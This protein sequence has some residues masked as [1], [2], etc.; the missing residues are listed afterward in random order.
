MTEPGARFSSPRSSRLRLIVLAAVTVL[1]LACWLAFKKLDPLA[2]LEIHATGEKVAL[3]PPVSPAVPVVA[4]SGPAVSKAAG[5]TSAPPPQP[6][7]E[8][9]EGVKPSFDIVRVSPSGDAVIAGR[10][11][12]G[13]E[14]TIAGNGIEV[15]HAQADGHGQWVLLTPVPLGT[16]GQELQLR[17]R[18][19]DGRSAVGDTPVVVLIPEPAAS[20]EKRAL[21]VLLPP[22][23]AGRLLKSE[24]VAGSPATSNRPNLDAVDYDDGGNIRFAGTA[25]PGATVRVYIDN[26]PVGDASADRAGRWA[27]VPRGTVAVGDHRLRL[28]QLATA[29]RTVARTEFPFQHTVIYDA[30]RDQIR[31]PNLIYPGQLF[32]I[33]TPRP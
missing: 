33:P 25:S 22:N 10:A 23:S 6:V 20:Q 17:S 15:G 5:P 29:G 30:K 4:Q 7:A 14:V 9:P 24:P 26:A 32:S 3:G 16:G 2:A 31:D 11:S 19:P 28:D 18:T 8:G 12:P 13:A 27:L 1:A 21:V